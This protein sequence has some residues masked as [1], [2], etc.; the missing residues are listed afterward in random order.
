MEIERI[1]VEEEVNRCGLFKRQN[2]VKFKAMLKK[3]LK[4]LNMEEEFVNFCGN[5]HKFRKIPD[6]FFKKKKFTQFMSTISDEYSLKTLLDRIEDMSDRLEQINTKNF[7]PKRRKVIG[8]FSSNQSR[9]KFMIEQTEVFGFENNALKNEVNS[10]SD[11]ELFFWNDVLEVLNEGE[12]VV[13]YKKKR[14]GVVRSYKL[15]C[16]EKYVDKYEYLKDSVCKS[17]MKKVYEKRILSSS[18]RMKKVCIFLKSNPQVRKYCQTLN[19]SILDFLA[20][21]QSAEQFELDSPGTI[22][23]NII[24]MKRQLF[25]WT[26]KH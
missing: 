23:G 20:S 24:K 26:D 22:I 5:T 25:T 16:S 4:D 9:D 1:N 13:A 6:V 19:F 18:L 8:I 14:T 7:S 10:D 21:Y 17:H 12:G 2:L 3:I 11:S 15:E